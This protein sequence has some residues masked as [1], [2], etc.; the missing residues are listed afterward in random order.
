[1]GEIVDNPCLF[2]NGA[3]GYHIVVAFGDLVDQ[4]AV[5]VVHID[6]VVAVAFAGEEPTLAVFEEH[7][8]VGHFDIG[9]VLLGV[10][11]GDSSGMG[12]SQKQFHLVLK[13][14]HTHQS[15]NLGV[16]SPLDAGHILVVLTAD[17]EFEGLLGFE[18][19]DEDIYHAVVLT[20]LGVF[21]SVILW[22]EFA[23]HLHGVLFYLA[24]VETI[25]GDALA[26]GRP[27]KAFGDGKFLFIHPVGGTVD[28]FVHFAIEGNLRF[29]EGVEGHI[30][31]V[32]VADI[33]HHLAVGREG[34]EALLARL[35]D[36][37]DASVGHITY[38]IAADTTVTVDGFEFGAQ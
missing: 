5:E 12:I 15:K 22:I 10:E 30:V 35:R 16:L 14:A 23:P 21:V 28:D 11:G 7:P 34:G 1:M 24:L 25:E 26:V 20:S 19:I 9:I 17:I 31:K 29:L 36:A 18:V 27:V 38:I 2:I 3:D 8:S 6:V 13:T 37:L 32:I 33:G 4:L